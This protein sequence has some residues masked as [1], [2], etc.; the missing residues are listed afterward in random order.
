[1]SRQFSVLLLAG[2]FCAFGLALSFSAHAGTLSD[3]V[4]Y[5]L[6][7]GAQQYPGT[8][9][10]LD[11]KIPEDIE[12]LGPSKQILTWD[13]T[14]GLV[15]PATVVLTEP[16]DPNYISDI[17][18]LTVNN[19]GAPEVLTFTFTS[20]SETSLIPPKDI[21]VS[22][23][24]NGDAAHPLDQNGFLNITRD[25]FPN[26]NVGQEPANILVESDSDVPEPATAGLLAFGGLALMLVRRL[27]WRPQSPQ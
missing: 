21:S 1:M 5:T 23:P 8:I 24:E 17:M 10:L 4:I 16:G 14:K 6:Q 26:F 7:N 25:L 22:I 13:A 15:L 2:T 9:Y 19:A 3:E 18:T 11:Q 12:G 20:D 27:L